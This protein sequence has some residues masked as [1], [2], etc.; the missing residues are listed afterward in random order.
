[1]GQL[2]SAVTAYFD[3]LNGEGGIQTTPALYEN[4]S[5]GAQQQTAAPAGA[6]PAAASGPTMLHPDKMNKQARAI[7]TKLNPA[8]GKSV[9]FVQDHKGVSRYLAQPSNPKELTV[10]QLRPL[11]AYILSILAVGDNVFLNLNPEKLLEP[12]ENAR[13]TASNTKLPS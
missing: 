8:I 6:A 1:M 4:E 7:L 3:M 10:D 13:N 9:V 11:G 12:E 2:S 5:M